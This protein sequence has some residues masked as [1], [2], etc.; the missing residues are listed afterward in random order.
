MHLGINC[1]GCE[2]SICGPRY[3]CLV[4]PDYD[5]CKECHVREKHMQHDMMKI[6]TPDGMSGRPRYGRGKVVGQG[7]AR[8]PQKVNEP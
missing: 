3:K 6:V 2:G 4:C 1:N 7:F 8:G 5:L